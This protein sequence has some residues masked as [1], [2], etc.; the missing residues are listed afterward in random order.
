ML[1]FFALNSPNSVWRPG[2]ARTRW[3]SYS[4]PPDSLAAIRGPTSKGRER[5]R[6]GRKEGKRKG[7]E[8]GWCPPDDFFARRPC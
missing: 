4:A 2:S 1:Y 7:G 8:G 5:E 3:G 6:R